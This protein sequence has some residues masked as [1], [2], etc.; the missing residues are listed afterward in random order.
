[1]VTIYPESW[2]GRLGRLLLDLLAVAWTAGWALAGWTVYRLVSGLEVVADSITR[3]GDTFN[4]WVGVFRSASPGGIPGLSGALRGLADGLQRSAGDPLVRDGVL[5]HTR[6]EQVA[7]ALG[8]FVAV[9]PIVSITGL[10]LLWRTRDARELSAAAAFVLSA[11]RT[12]RIE[13]ANAVLAH[14]AVA[15]LPFRQLMRASA[16]PIGDLTSGRHEALAGAMLR[17]VGMR[18]LV[19]SPRSDRALASRR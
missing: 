7:T 16:D 13:Q 4:G 5:A 14:R 2:P 9:L 3:T 10:Y 19:A 15:L 18:P 11:E 1:V 12:G 17:R 6:I 8:L